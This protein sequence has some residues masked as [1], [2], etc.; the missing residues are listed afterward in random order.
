M[1]AM[2][3]ELAMSKKGLEKSQTEAAG[4][5]ERLGGEVGRLTEKELEMSESHAEAMRLGGEMERLGNDLLFNLFI[6]LR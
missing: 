5:V 3:E 2:E 4:D 1:L 6:D